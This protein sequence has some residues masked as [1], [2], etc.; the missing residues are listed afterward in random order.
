MSIADSHQEASNVKIHK[1]LRDI[2]VAVA[3]AAMLVAS[4]GAGGNVS[5]AAAHSHGHGHGSSHSSAAQLPTPPK[6]PHG[7]PTQPRHYKPPTA[8]VSGTKATAKHTLATAVAAPA[9]AYSWGSSGNATTLVL[10]DTTN[11]WGWLGELY[12][13][14]SGNLA[15]HF[16]AVTAEPV[17]DY[18]AGQ[19]DNFTSTIYIGSTYNEPLPAAFLNDAL[20][21]T[22]PVV[23]A[24]SNIWQLSG[25]PGSAANLAFQAKYGWDPS[26]SYFDSTDNPLSVSYKGETFTRSADNG[27]DIL[28]PH[29]TNASTVNVLATANCTD[30]TGAPVN[31]APIAQTTGTSLP[32][33]IRSANLTYVGEVP[34]SYMT[35]TDRYLIFA[36]L[37]FN[38]DAPTARVTHRALVRLEDVNPTTD[39]AALRAIAS[40]LY[41]QHVPFSIAV[42]PQ[43][44][45]PNGFYN[46]GVPQSIS[47]AQAPALVAALKYA[48]SKGGVILEEGYTHQYSNIANPYDGVSGDDAE[49]YRAQCSITEY[50][51]YQYDA[52]CQNTDWVTWTG[53]LPGDSTAWA[54]NRVQTGQALFAQAGLATPTIWE[55]PHYFAS[56]A[57]YVGIDSVYSSRY[58]RDLFVSG[59][60]SGQALDYSRI[61]GQFFPYSVRDVYGESMI[62][63]NLGDYEPTMENNNPPR[64]PAKLINEA[65]LNLAVTQ[66]VASFFYDPNYP[67]SD[68][69]QIVSGIKGLGYTFVSPTA[70]G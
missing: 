16:G 68:L 46:N 60:L 24:N 32:W 2:V 39:P 31:C 11:T 21:T 52:P 1:R 27:A 70:I 28:A 45:D 51:P 64:P 20:A 53:P 13:M 43:Y 63:E 17:V 7:H 19:M 33:A 3:T 54:T 57:D 55:T 66:G 38:A 47:L 5:A 37:L 35:E 34:F 50:P 9:Q 29:I 36:D 49:F 42:I 12:A 25:T 44:L 69:Q 59:L 4:L 15:T 23:W 10:Y 14:G 22:Q 48:A 26:T 56:A 67:L 41:R 18:V 8:L 58:G 65:Q 30:S 62:P 61:F 40:Y 6:P